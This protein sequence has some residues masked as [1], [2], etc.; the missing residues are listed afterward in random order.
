MKAVI[1]AAGEGRRLQPITSTRP[2]HLIK[3]GGKPIL[4]HCLNALKLSGIS[5][6]VIV[7]NYMADTIQQYFG[8]GKKLGIRIDYV[9]QEA[10]TGTGNAVSVVEP[11]VKEEFMLVYGDLLFT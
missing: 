7:V 3:I 5:E 4:N 11:H 10:A 1:L 6:V 2:K 8:D 9:K